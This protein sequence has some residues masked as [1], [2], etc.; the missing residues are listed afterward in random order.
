MYSS[1]ASIG[2][3]LLL[4]LLLL[5]F[6]PLNTIQIK[7]VIISVS[8]LKTTRQER[9]FIQFKTNVARIKHTGVTKSAFTQLLGL[10][11]GV[12]SSQLL[13]YPRCDGDWKGVASAWKRI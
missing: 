4:L 5:L 13:L 11:K 10:I 2:H 3:L 6:H 12:T 7:C 1:C 9:S 8:V